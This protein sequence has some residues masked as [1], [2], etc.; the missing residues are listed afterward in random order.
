MAV[1]DVLIIILYFAMIIAI[2]FIVAKKSVKT[3]DDASVAGHKLGIFLGGIGKAANSAGGSSSVGGT[4]WGYSLGISGMWYAV[5]EGLT[6]VL[7]L[8]II[9]RIWR[10]LYRTRSSSV[11]KFFGYRW[12]KGGVLFAGACNAV[13]Y[14]AFVGAQIIATATVIKL[15][16]GW[17]YIPA[18][19]V[20][21]AIIII[22]CTAGGLKAIVITDVIQMSLIIAGMLIIMPPI[23]FGKAGPIAASMG[24]EGTGIIAV[25]DAISKSDVISY[26]V[27]F[28]GPTA[29]GF[30]WPYVIGAIILPT[31]L[32]AGVA[33]AAF[34]YQA[35]IES[36]DKAFKSFIMV[37]FLY[38]PVSIAVVLM[39][40]CAMFLYG[41]AY[42]P[43]AVGG[44]GLDPNMILSQLINDFLPKGLTGF[45]LAAILSAT[46]STS[47]TCL[48]CSVTCL[49]EDVI[50]PLRKKAQ[51]DPKQS[52]RLFRLCM[53]IVG[54]GTIGITVFATDIITLLTTAY[55][56]VVAGLWVPM[57]ATLFAK[58]TTKSATYITMIVGLVLYG[59]IAFAP[60][61]FSFLPS[62]IVA[63][64]LYLTLP[65][66]IVLQI[67]ISACTQK[68]DHGRID[69]YFT[70]EWE[71]SPGNWEKHPEIIDEN[72]EVIIPA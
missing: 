42:L 39:G 10:V 34:Q 18:L 62:A 16:L 40:M 1:I 19:L 2:G 55:A 67:V 12:G 37:P 63:S 7:Y 36:A 64:P 23:V 48:I 29:A 5:S 22:Y 26:M 66:S 24:G 58:K 8:P 30:G 17:E 35:A 45:L 53:V 4:S 15:M 54:I 47:S 44:G 49:T 68:S 57:M 72:G 60:G 70:D 9:K 28:G 65:L 61:A 69:A 51:L 52:L 41:P 25:W 3:G 31:L 46:M 20:S 33:Q 6:Y 32:I 13:A 56:A 38:I 43:E 11:G 21:T 27:D 59:L 14:M 50:K 71:K